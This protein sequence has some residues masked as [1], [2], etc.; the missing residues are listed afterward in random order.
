VSISLLGH[1]PAFLGK[2]SHDTIVVALSLSF[3]NVVKSCYL[4]LLSWRKLRKKKKKHSTFENILPHISTMGALQN[5]I[6][7]DSGRYIS[8]LQLSF[9]FTILGSWSC[10]HPPKWTLTCTIILILVSSTF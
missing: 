5:K 6:P 10:D 1:A 3:L 9:F 7:T 2:F 4:V 8:G